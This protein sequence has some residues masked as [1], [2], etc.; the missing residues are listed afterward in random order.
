LIDMCDAIEAQFGPDTPPLV[1]LFMARGLT[2]LGRFDEAA[3]VVKPLEDNPGLLPKE[4]RPTLTN[5]AE[6][7]R[8]Y[9]SLLSSLN[10]VPTVRRRF[11]IARI[12]ALAA[13]DP[14]IWV[15]LFNADGPHREEIV[16]WIY[17]ADY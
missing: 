10:S 3:Q 6:D 17:P 1:T 15:S 16:T 8:I 5:W 12:L 9:P 14:E 2:M 4:Y 7:A 11:D 13:R